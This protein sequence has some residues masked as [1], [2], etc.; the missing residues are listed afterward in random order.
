MKD[1]VSRQHR[2]HIQSA[3]SQLEVVRGYLE[4][5]LEEFLGLVVLLLP[6]REDARELR[7]SQGQT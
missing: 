6:F 2:L 7:K 4:T 5:F 3:G 1:D